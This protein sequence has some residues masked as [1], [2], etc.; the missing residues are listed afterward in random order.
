MPLFVSTIDLGEFG[1]SYMKPS[2]TGFDIKKKIWV[3]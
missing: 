2:I 1:I 3:L